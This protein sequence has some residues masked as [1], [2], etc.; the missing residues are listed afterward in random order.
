MSSSPLRGDISSG[1]SRITIISSGVIFIDTKTK[2]DHPIDP[3][4]IC[5]GIFQN[6]AGGQN[7][8][9]IEQE[10]HLSF[11]LLPWGLDHRV[12]RVLSASA[13]LLPCSHG[14]VASMAWAFMILSL[15]AIQPHVLVTV[16][17]E[18][19]TNQLDMSTFFIYFFKISFMI[20]HRFS[21]FVFFFSLP[22]IFLFF[23]F[24]KF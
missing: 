3:V 17:Y 15:F 10:D 14:W 18:D 9:F 21:N 11:C 19:V 1:H 7:C 8:S 22:V 4:S 2:F 23:I 24:C 13:S 20:L 6:E 12:V 5:L 16:Q